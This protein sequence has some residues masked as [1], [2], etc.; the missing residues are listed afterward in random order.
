MMI[1]ATKLFPNAKALKSTI[2][3]NDNFIYLYRNKRF[4]FV[5]M[6]RCPKATKNSYRKC[7]HHP[8]INQHV[9]K[10]EVPNFLTILKMSSKFYIFISPATT[11]HLLFSS[12]NFHFEAEKPNMRGSHVSVWI[13]TRPSKY[14]KYTVFPHTV[15]NSYCIP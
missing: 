11:L 3:L 6:E 1:I 8:L 7:S 4:T 5:L 15:Q 9:L 2:Q 13:L 14:N 10:K 12:L